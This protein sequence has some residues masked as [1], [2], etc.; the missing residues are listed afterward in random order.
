MAFLSISIDVAGSTRLKQALVEATGDNPRGRERL[1]EDYRKLLYAVERDFLMAV[2]S[3]PVLLS[4]R[5]YLIKS[6]GDEYWFAYD[7]DEVESNDLSATA[8]AL[9][10]ALLAVLEMERYF[11]IAG[12]D[13]RR[14]SRARFG[15]HY[16]VPVKVCLDLV[17]EAVELNSDRYHHLKD[18]ISLLRHDRS[19]IHAV[20]RQFSEICGR[21]NLG[22]PDV[23]DSAHPILAR[24]DYIGLEIDRFFRMSKY[25]LPLLP[26]IGEAMFRLLG[27]DLGP[28]AERE[29][30]QNWQ[31]TR[32]TAM[33]V[34]KRLSAAMM[35]GL[36]DDYQV[37][38]L[39]SD[40]VLGRLLNQRPS[41]ENRLLEPTYE[42]MT[43]HGFEFPPHR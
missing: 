2:A 32:G 34:P 20:D 11:S 40:I 42:F 26:C 7:I 8:N 9:L 17:R 6:I 1:Y 10:D 21:L 14:E 43:T 23:F 38:H 30:R 16:Q 25:A 18:I 13:D 22:A 12:T 28:A 35:K 15:F 36:S 27:V 19:P 37:Y 41:D 24:Q 5:L 3:S 4:N 31:R 39:V 33:I 29:P